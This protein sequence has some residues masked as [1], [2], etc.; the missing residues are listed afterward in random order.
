MQSTHGHLRRAPL[1]AALESAP[2]HVQSRSSSRAACEKLLEAVDSVGADL[3]TDFFLTGNLLCAVFFEEGVI[4]DIL[5]CEL[6][7]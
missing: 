4:I 1:R 7:V 3:A 6:F 5:D 2:L